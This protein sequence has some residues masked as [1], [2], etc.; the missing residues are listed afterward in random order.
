M[1]R[2]VHIIG[3]GL[4]GLSA[5]VELAAKGVPVH[6]YEASTFA[7]GRCRS[8]QDRDLDRLIDNGS[9]LM[10]ACNGSV[11][12]YLAGIGTLDTLT[13]PATPDFP[14]IDLATDDRW[15]LRLTPGR[16]PAWIFDATRRVAGTR[17]ADYL[18]ALR[19]LFAGRDTVL[20]DIL[21]PDTQL[22]RRLLAPLIIGILNTEPEA[23]S[24]AILRNV[25]LECFGRGGSACRPMVV[26]EGL[27]ESFITPALDFITQRGG[28]ITY[29]KRLQ[30]FEAAGDRV[31]QLNFTDGPLAIGDGQSVILAVTASSAANILPGTSTPKEFRPIVSVHFKAKLRPLPC[32]FIGVVGGTAEWIF[33]RGDVVSVTISC[34][35]ALAKSTPDEIAALV[36]QDVAKVFKL[37]ADAPIAPFRVVKELRATFACTPDQVAQRPLP[38]TAWQN[39]WLAGE[40]VD[41]GL[42]STIEGAIRSGQRAAGLV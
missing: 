17:P 35:T 38:Q 39:L 2:A 1:T 25:F 19:I 20:G 28:T 14:F 40:W 32:G 6:L 3:A 4:A 42:P 5:G 26:A 18:A 36:W 13:G 33:Q 24:A 21:S 7:G 9:H 22:Y 37:R 16:F 30:G 34:A 41:N 11:R 31:T 12:Q 8:Y 27:S 23:A 29:N 15:T 10:L